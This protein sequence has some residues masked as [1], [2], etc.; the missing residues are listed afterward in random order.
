MISW[1]KSHWRKIAFILI[2]LFGKEQKVSDHITSFLVYLFTGRFIVHVCVCA[3][4]HVQ[5]IVFSVSAVQEQCWHNIH[6]LRACSIVWLVQSVPTLQKTRKGDWVHSRVGNLP[7]S[8]KL[9]ACY[10]IGPLQTRVWHIG[11]LLTKVFNVTAFS[12]LPFSLVPRLLP[13][14]KTGR[15]R[16]LPIFLHGEEP[17][18]EA[19]TIINKL[20]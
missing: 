13:V 3:C 16:L 15:P 18:Y 7:S 19:T 9:P 10:S 5:C 1:C 11:C 8:E 6:F 14:Q 17:G 2:L 20:V 12:A 4:M